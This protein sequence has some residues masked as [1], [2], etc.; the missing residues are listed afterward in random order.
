MFVREKKTSNGAALQLVRN[1]R[2]SDGKVRQE[3][4]LSLGSIK[5]PDE[6]RKT[7][8]HEVEYRMNGYGRLEPLEYDVAALV[9]AVTCRLEA[10]RRIYSHGDKCVEMAA[11]SE[12]TRRHHD[13]FPEICDNVM[14]SLEVGATDSA[15]SFLFEGEP[16]VVTVANLSDGHIET[17]LDLPVPAGMLFDRVDSARVPVCEGRAKMALGPWEFRAFEVRA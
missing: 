1:R 17:T 2:G 6:L 12:R 8:A 16:Y 9:D 3:I 11:L 15:M 13:A 10:G 7:V 4:V 14:S 5:V